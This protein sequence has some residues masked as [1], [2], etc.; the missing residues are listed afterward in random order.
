MATTF[1]T[2]WTVDFRRK[3]LFWG[4]LRLI[5]EKKH[6]K[7]IKNI[8]QQAVHDVLMDDNYRLCNF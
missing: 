8:E 6:R 3:A 5:L 1:T 4:I 7:R 2:S